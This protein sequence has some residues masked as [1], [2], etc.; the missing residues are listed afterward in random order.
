M[1]KRKIKD[2]HH[3]LVYIS[4][5]LVDALVEKLENS[6]FKLSLLVQLRFHKRLGECGGRR[7]GVVVVVCCCGVVHTPIGGHCRK[8]VVVRVRLIDHD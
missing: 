5:L 1:K 7:G 2:L 8:L 4:L 6:H 3:P